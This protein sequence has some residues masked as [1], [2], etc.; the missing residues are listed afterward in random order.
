MHQFGEAL[1]PCGILLW[2]TQQ[3]ADGLLPTA[4]SRYPGYS[5]TLREHLTLSILVRKYMGLPRQYT[6]D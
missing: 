6:S 1:L 5:N 2:S 3:P 4:M